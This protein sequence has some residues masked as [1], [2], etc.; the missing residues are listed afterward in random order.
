MLLKTFE[1]VLIISAS[2]NSFIFSR[3]VDDNVLKNSWVY[4]L[5]DDVH[6]VDCVD[7]FF[8]STRD[9]QKLSDFEDLFPS[10]SEY[11]KAPG[12]DLIVSLEELYKIRGY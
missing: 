8:S 6:D 3:L 5:E 12:D 1:L 4:E 11:L 9:W 2:F 7:K 10:C